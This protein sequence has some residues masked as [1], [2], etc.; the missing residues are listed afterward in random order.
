M[1]SRMHPMVRLAERIA[2][3]EAGRFTDTTIETDAFREGDQTT[4]ALYAEAHAIN[5]RFKYAG[6]A[7]GVFM[8]IAVCARLLRLSVLR[9]ERDY[10]IDKGACLSCAR[11]FKYCP[12]EKP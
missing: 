9:H 7:F 4:A 6:A 10:T 1:L 12:V 11:C 2:A 5:E 3:E 8:G